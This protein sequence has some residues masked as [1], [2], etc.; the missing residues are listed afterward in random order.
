VVY[1][2]HNTSSAASVLSIWQPRA[3]KTPRTS[4]RVLRTAQREE[5]RREQFELC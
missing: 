3:G 1:Q 5:H 2:E 4:K